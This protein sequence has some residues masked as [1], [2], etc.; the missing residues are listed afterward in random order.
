MS[1]QRYSGSVRVRV[2]YVGGAL[3]RRS[4]RR[5]RKQESSS[6]M[7]TIEMDRIQ[8]WWMLGMTWQAWSLTMGP[9]DDTGYVPTGRE[10]S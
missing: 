7:Q 9:I 8:A 4:R 2:T 3:P 5:G 1:T 10:L 6:P